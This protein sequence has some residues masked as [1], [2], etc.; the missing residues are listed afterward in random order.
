MIPRE[1]IA[2]ATATRRRCDRPRLEDREYNDRD[3]DA[4]RHG[5]EPTMPGLKPQ[6]FRI[7]SEVR[8]R[9]A[10]VEDREPTFESREAC[11]DS[12]A[13]ARRPCHSRAPSPGVPGTSSEHP[14]L[15][16]RSTRGESWLLDAIAQRQDGLQCPERHPAVE[17]LLGL[18]QRAVGDRSEEHTSELQSRLH[19]V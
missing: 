12:R 8:R 3:A 1:A 9:Y 11:D 4:D 7:T 14:R 19:L 17:V 10:L 6:G 13:P 2:R 18:R 15:A 16:P 5:R